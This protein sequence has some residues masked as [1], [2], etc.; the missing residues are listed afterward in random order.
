MPTPSRRP[1]LFE[2]S[3]SVRLLQSKNCHT[4]VYQ[5]LPILLSISLPLLLTPRLT[6]HIKIIKEIQQQNHKEKHHLLKP[7]EIMLMTCSGVFS[8]NLPPST[9]ENLL[10]SK[11]WNQSTPSPY[12][13]PSS[14]GHQFIRCQLSSLL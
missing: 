6:I 10:P 14:H 11:I 2:I 9:W 1:T 8:G 3:Y 7:H 12:L 4:T 5:P 13:P